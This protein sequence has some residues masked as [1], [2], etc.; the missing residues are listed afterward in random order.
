MACMCTC[1]RARD[2]CEEDY[3]T[4]RF[5]FLSLSGERE[6]VDV[7]F[8]LSFLVIGHEHGHVHGERGGQY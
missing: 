8:V 4:T 3:E 1:V 2:D 7:L 6:N 5:C